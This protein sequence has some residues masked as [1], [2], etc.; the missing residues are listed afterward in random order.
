MVTDE[1]VNVIDRSNVPAN[2]STSFFLN[3]APFQFTIL[4]DISNIDK[5]IN[6]LQKPFSL[7]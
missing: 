4:T 7:D 3:T 2:G 5:H 1:V 6:I